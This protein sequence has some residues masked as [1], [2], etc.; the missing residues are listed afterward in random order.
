[1]ASGV[2]V[3]PQLSFLNTE[4]SF[5]RQAQVG[6]QS[7]L[8]VMIA[9]KNNQGT[10]QLAASKVHKLTESAGEYRTATSAKLLEDELDN[11]MASAPLNREQ[12]ERAIAS[13]WQVNA[14][15]GVN[16]EN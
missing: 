6:S 5:C 7:E 13:L 1:M 15:K 12:E 3:T 2:T 9:C 4:N 10:W 11:M 14:V 8:N 16:D